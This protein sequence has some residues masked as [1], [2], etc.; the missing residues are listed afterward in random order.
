MTADEVQTLVASLD[1]IPSLVETHISWVIL[2]DAFAYKLKK[3][4]QYSFLDFTTLERRR[5][6]CHRELELNRRL[7]P[8][9]YLDVLGI[10]RQGE[11]LSLAPEGRQGELMDHALK[12]QRLDMEMEM[13]KRL[14]RGEID[15]AYLKVLAQKIATFHRGAT[16]VHAPSQSDPDSYQADFNDILNH[17]ATFARLLGKNAK[18]RLQGVVATSDHYLATHAHLI[19][20]RLQQGYVRDVHGDLHT[21]NIFA[22]PDPVIFDCI[23]FNDHFRQ[24]DVLNEIAFLC[25]D[26]RAMGFG[27]H[28]QRFQ[29]VYFEAFPAMPDPGS[30]GL[31]IWFKCY[32]ANVRAKVNALRAAQDAQAPEIANEM[33][34]YLG[35][36][37]EYAQRLRHLEHS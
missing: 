14:A 20:Q 9:V 34:R 23:E 32:R 8:H 3:P 17:A 12:M 10:Y 18:D 29:E 16:I 15:F 11:R 26:L 30:K 35:L 22:Y 2:T 31:F 6:Y 28:A 25:M 21:R 36:M 1:G 27:G 24:I 5:H 37:E 7:A 19:R 4:V 13:D 33:K